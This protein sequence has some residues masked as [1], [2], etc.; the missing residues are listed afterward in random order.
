MY[1]R[2]EAYLSP[3]KKS[4]SRIEPT[5]T[6]KEHDLKNEPNKEA[7]DSKSDGQFKSDGEDTSFE[8]AKTAA[9]EES[10]GSAELENLNWTADVDQ[11]RHPDVNV[12]DNDAG[13]LL[14][15]AKLTQRLVERGQNITRYPSS[16]FTD[17]ITFGELGKS[18]SAVVSYNWTV[19]RKFSLHTLHEL[20][21]SSIDLLFACLKLTSFLYYASI[22]VKG[23]DQFLVIV[24]KFR[25]LFSTK[26]YRKISLSQDTLRCS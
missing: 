22:R 26:A 1:F 6:G 12:H 5:C 23:C 15:S 16:L 9:S 3:E 21:S 7:I 11:T 2:I 14:A 19:P 10:C 25:L 18:F 17:D 8:S 24:H 4:P 13:D 20:V